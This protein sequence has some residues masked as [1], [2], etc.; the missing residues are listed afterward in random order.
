MSRPLHIAD[1]CT[2]NMKKR[3]IAISS[4]SIL[5]LALIIILGHHYNNQ[6]QKQTSGIK[7]LKTHG[8]YNYIPD[9]DNILQLAFVT[10]GEETLATEK[11]SFSFD[12]DLV[13][14]ENLELSEWLSIKDYK[15][16]LLNMHI[17]ITDNQVEGNQIK[18]NHVILNGITY[19]QFGS[20]TFQVASKDPNYSYPLCLKAH[21]AG[22]YGIGLHS[23]HAT[24][25]NNNAEPIIITQVEVPTYD[26]AEAYL[27]LNDKVHPLGTGAFTI[28]PNQT[29]E[30]NLT[31]SNCEEDSDVYYVSPI[32][33][34]SFH[35][36][37]YKLPL[38]YFVAGTLLTESEAL[39][40]AT[41]MDWE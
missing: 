34:Y 19:D 16:W 13:S 25:I 22:S 20:L 3:W 28:P 30:L 9:R 10:K 8:S 18:V 7:F 17:R 27:I 38:F 5:F 39:Q 31:L 37:D 21:D 32:I 23:Y 26:A 15:L 2:I 1:S 40:L 33:H 41:S 14:V 4:L 24:F 6:L 11:P 35:G 12:S 36:K 29:A